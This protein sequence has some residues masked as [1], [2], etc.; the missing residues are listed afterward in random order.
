MPITE[1]TLLDPLSAVMEE[2]ASPHCARA[3]CSLTA[4]QLLRPL[5]PANAA[6]CAL[7]EA[8]LTTDARFKVFHD[9]AHVAA[10]LRLEAA[11]SPYVAAATAAAETARRLEEMC[12]RHLNVFYGGDSFLAAGPLPTPPPGCVLVTDD[13]VPE[14]ETPLFFV[15][16]SDAAAKDV[17]DTA[18]STTVELASVAYKT[19]Y[20][21]PMLILSPEVALTL[22]GENAVFNRAALEA[23]WLA[24][25]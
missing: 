8:L 6:Q 2:L 1:T 25:R 21:R 16:T 7:L 11:L 13:T 22:V 10:R 23:M 5:E 4:A 9:A 24:A 20:G 14:R 19:R 18:D 12:F 3:S 17:L 15:R